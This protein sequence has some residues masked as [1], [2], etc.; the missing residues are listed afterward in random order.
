MKNSNSVNEMSS[1]TYRYMRALMYDMFVSYPW[2]DEFVECIKNPDFV[3]DP[4]STA[5]DVSW[6]KACTTPIPKDSVFPKENPDLLER[7]RLQL[8][9]LS[10][11]KEDPSH[12]EKLLDIKIQD[13]SGSTVSSEFESYVVCKAAAQRKDYAVSAEYF[14]MTQALEKNQCAS[15]IQEKMVQLCDAHRTKIQ[16]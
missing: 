12:C 2:R 1:P 11:R 3:I 8:S 4:K 9:Y 15:F 14:R 7:Y 10:F 16:K 5:L 6:K 13:G